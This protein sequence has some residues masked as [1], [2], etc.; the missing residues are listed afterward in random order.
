MHDEK[1]WNAKMNG[2]G[3]VGIIS[4][5]GNKLRYIRELNRYVSSSVGRGVAIC[6]PFFGGGAF[7]RSIVAKTT[8]PVFVAETC[9]P[10]CNWWRHI[11]E[12]S[13][14]MVSKMSEYRLEFRDAKTDRYVF[15][16]LRDGWNE[17]NR[18]DPFGL[19]TAAMFWV[20]IYQSTNNLVR[21]NMSGKYN[22]TWGKG[23]NVPNPNEVFSRD[24]LQN[25]EILR[26]GIT[27]GCFENDFSKA[28]DS[29]IEHGHGGICLLD[30]PYILSNGLY[31][32]YGWTVENLGVLVE[33]ARE[34]DEQNVAWIW[35]DYLSHDGE[36]HP[37]KKVI[38]ENF[39]YR[40]LNAK[41][42]S[43]PNG[44]SKERNEV[45]IFGKA[46][47]IEAKTQSSFGF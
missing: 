5:P 37:Y 23:R 18:T 45:V 24:A 20:L 7:T 46:V 47:E 39:R 33:K 34:L 8:G 26:N 27:C 40:S 15:D 44:I 30:P 32:R 12:N 10:L 11:L 28:I 41:R 29:F 13:R 42:S 19:D 21:F 25:I 22:Q 14:D 1:I 16:C 43:R 6:E 17:K 4:W 9:K 2:S 36:E 35:T 38:Q 3:F 31:D